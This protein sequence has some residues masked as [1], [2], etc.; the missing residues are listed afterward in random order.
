MPRLPSRLVAQASQRNP[1]LALVL[2]TCRDPTSA[3][4]E[5]KWLRDYAVQHCVHTRG[6]W[7]PLLFR[8]CAARSRGYPLQYLLGSEFFGDLEIKCKPGVLIPRSET[9]TAVTHFVNQ[10]NPAAFNLPP[11]LRVLDLCTGTGCISLLFAHLFPKQRT[12]VKAL[13]I[14]GV[15]IAPEAVQLA[16]ENR[17]ALLDQAAI[18]S[19]QNLRYIQADLFPPEE[20][21]Q[22]SVPSLI[23]RLE[24]LG[25]LEWDVILSNPPYISPNGFNRDTSRSVRNFE[26]KLALVPMAANGLADADHGDVFYPRILE[27]ADQVGGKV[28]LLEVAD[29]DQAERVAAMALRYDWEGVEIWRD[30]LFSHDDTKYIGRIRVLGTGHGRSVLCWRKAASSWLRRDGESNTTG[31]ASG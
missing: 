9:A 7:R 10:F 23:G 3:A 27:I 6:N 2:R 12:P 28:V 8:L 13:Q 25:Q 30:E 18:S 1:L 20:S 29:L 21:Q 15:D 4:L 17:R 14:V 22:T 31:V 5:L 16:E 24:A 11:R 26:P 19:L